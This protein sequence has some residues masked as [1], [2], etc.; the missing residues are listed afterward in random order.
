MESIQ[1]V[2]KNGEEEE[3]ILLLRRRNLG[4][5]VDLREKEGDKG[6]KNGI[7]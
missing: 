3:E 7:F 5:E 2:R 1:G 6:I 4:R